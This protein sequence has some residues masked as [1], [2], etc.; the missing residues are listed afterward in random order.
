MMRWM[1]TPSCLKLSYH[2]CLV[3]AVRSRHS[4]TFRK[5]EVHN[6][7]CTEDFNS[8]AITRDL[9]G[10]H[11]FTQGWGRCIG[12]LASI[13]TVPQCMT[14]RKLARASS[15][16]YCPFRPAVHAVCVYAATRAASTSSP[17]YRFQCACQASIQGSGPHSDRYQLLFVGAGVW[18]WWGTYG[19]A[20]DSWSG[21]CIQCLPRVAKSDCTPCSLLHAVKQCVANMISGT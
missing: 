4:S 15:R 17:R 21:L 14:M 2:M 16:T 5:A 18:A 19:L 10:P 11:A 3:L 1:M 9:R 8:Q 6:T 20:D 12:F 7:V 13:N